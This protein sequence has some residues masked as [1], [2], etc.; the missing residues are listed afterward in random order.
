MSADRTLRGLLASG[1]DEAVAIAARGAPPLSYAALRALIDR[2]QHSLNELGIG[3]GDRVAIV[4]PNGAEMAAAF[5]CVA[6]AAAAPLNPA[7]RQDEFEFYLEDLRAKALIVEAGSESPVLRAAEKLGVAVIALTPEAQAVGEA[8]GIRF[9]LSVDKRIA[10]AESIGAHKTSMLQDIE[11]GRATEID[12][13][14]GSVIE[15]AR[16]VNVPTAH[17]DAIYAVTKLLGETVARSGSGL[18]LTRQ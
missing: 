9:R 5:L 15:L 14:L 6:S 7:Y 12:A 11:H 3:R 16:L 18:W 8:F 17:L 1:R 13:L 10:G 4:L 2:T